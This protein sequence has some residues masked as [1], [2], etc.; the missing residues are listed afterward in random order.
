VREVGWVWTWEDER[1]NCGDWTGTNDLNSARL[2]VVVCGP[3]AAVERAEERAHFGSEGGGW[4]LVVHL[5][6]FGGIVEGFDE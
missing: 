2:V 5:P 1:K 4:R 6:S 3:A